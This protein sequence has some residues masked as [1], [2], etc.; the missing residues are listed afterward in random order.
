VAGWFNIEQ[1]DLF[2][3]DL[4]GNG[5]FI[6][7]RHI[8]FSLVNSSLVFGHFRHCHGLRNYTRREFY[9]ELFMPVTDLYHRLMQHMYEMARKCITINAE[10]NLTKATL[11][12]S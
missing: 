7:V 3:K 5:S 9:E 4:V 11:F 2:D 1:S 6:C 12:V 8:E 10:W